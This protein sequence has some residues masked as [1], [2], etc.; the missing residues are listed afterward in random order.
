MIHKGEPRDLFGRQGGDV[1]T[2]G[3]LVLIIAGAL[4]FFRAFLGALWQ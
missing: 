4:V 3:E 1:P 2:L